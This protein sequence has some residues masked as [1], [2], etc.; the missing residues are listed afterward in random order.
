MGKPERYGESE[1]WQQDRDAQQAYFCERPPPVNLATKQYHADEEPVPEPSCRGR[2]R[3]L[4]PQQTD[5]S[6]YVLD[7]MADLRAQIQTHD[8]NTFMLSY[9]GHGNRKNLRGSIPTQNTEVI[10]LADVLKVLD[11]HVTVS[12]HAVAFTI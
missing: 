3:P 10:Q 12:L 7:I 5:D 9:I 6:F 1:A 11:T 2:K 8:Y 4:L